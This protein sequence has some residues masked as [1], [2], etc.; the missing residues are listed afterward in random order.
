MFAKSKQTGGRIEPEH[1][2]G[3]SLPNALAEE[4]LH[5]FASRI[6]HTPFNLLRL[7]SWVSFDEAGYVRKPLF[8]SPE[9]EIA[10]TC[11][12]AG[13]SSTMHNHG[14]SA[15]VSVV[16]SGCLTETH[17]VQ[18]GGLWMPECQRQ[19]RR[20]ELMVEGR[21]TV[22]RVHNESSQPALALHFYSPPTQAIAQRE[23]NRVLATG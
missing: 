6:A 13:Q 9:W 17:Y 15:G 2:L 3:W 1:L 23:D 22:H 20:H 16:L 12:L 14:G 10:L 21:D 11:W 5:E 19:V 4:S 8:L 7:A 18:E